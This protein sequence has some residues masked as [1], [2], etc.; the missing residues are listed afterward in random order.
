M[1]NFQSNPAHLFLTAL[2]N[3]VFS[4]NSGKARDPVEKSGPS[5]EVLFGTLGIK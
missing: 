2:K 4:L 5:G 3:Y 1:E